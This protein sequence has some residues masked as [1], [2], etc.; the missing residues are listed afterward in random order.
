MNMKTA[1]AREEPFFRPEELEEIRRTFFDQGRTALESLSQEILGLEGEVPTPDRLRSTKRA[2]HTLK[3]DFA[4]VG[5]PHLSRLAHA[6]EDALVDVEEG[7]RP[8]GCRQT[9][10]L[11]VAVDTLRSGL[12]AGAR[13]EGEPRVDDL[14]ERLATVVDAAGATWDRLG[15][16]DRER[17]REARARGLHVVRM[18]L[19]PGSSRRNVR[20]SLDAVAKRLGLEVVAVLDGTGGSGR[21]VDVVALAS[22][23]FEAVASE[24]ARLRGVAATI[25]DL[26][27]EPELVPGPR[28]ASEPSSDG[29]MVR[30]ESRRVDEVLNLVGEMV[31]ARS[32]IAGVAEEIEARLPDE[33]A[34]RLGDALAILGRVL[35]DLQRSAMR[36]RMVP[37][38]RVFRRFTRVVRDL[39]QKKGKRVRLRIEGEST[40]LD[41]GI[42]DALEEPLLHLVRN[43]VDHGLE[44]PDERLA[45]G[46][47]EEGLVLLRAGREGNQILIEVQDDGRGIDAAAV[48]ARAVELGTVQ[49]E[50]AES[51]ADPEALQLVFCPGLSTAPEITETS[52]RGVGLDVVREAVE[53]LKGSVRAESTPGAGAVFML[54]VPLTVAII[55]ALLFRTGGRHLA[56]PLASVLEIARIRDVMIQPLQSGEV[57]RLRGEILGLVRLPRLLALPAATSEGFIVVLQCGAGRFGLAVDELL[58]EQELV[59][60]AVHDRWIRTPLVAGASVLGGGTLVLILDVP[61]IYRAGLALGGAP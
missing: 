56:V 59:I 54:R 6:L 17:L 53:A 46:K 8:I 26:Q 34:S 61:A 43:A 41:R 57:F 29:D 52:G 51:L 16:E 11:L 36:M 35:Q 44:S 39:A 37:A 9:D 22:R 15:Q 28:R 1:T 45:A 48:K 14:V 3:S 23:P 30:I 10:L 18:V 33:L 13:G 32:T 12:E 47:A 21:G 40:E 49:R 2:A 50:D 31:I 20:T 42:L 7:A 60:K 19:S 24:A 58:G 5:F 38:D 27:P 4:S 55:Q 25:E